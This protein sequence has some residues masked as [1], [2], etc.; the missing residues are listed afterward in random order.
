MLP[1]LKLTNGPP[2]VENIV[3]NNEKEEQ[4]NANLN[5]KVKKV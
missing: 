3:Q 1:T 5:K 4:D 2:V